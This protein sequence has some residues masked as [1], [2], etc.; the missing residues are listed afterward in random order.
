MKSWLL[1]LSFFSFF[2][3]SFLLFGE[4]TFEIWWLS[5]TS[6]TLQW[7]I[8]SSVN[9]FFENKAQV[10]VVLWLSPTRVHQTSDLKKWTWGTFCRGI[11]FSL[12]VSHRWLKQGYGTCCHIS[13]ITHMYYS[14]RQQMD[15]RLFELQ[16]WNTKVE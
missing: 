6:L 12:L 16:M 5:F 10:Y 15:N 9:R 4:Y 11:F 8:H 3:F 2:F 14:S 1:S 7:N 13:F